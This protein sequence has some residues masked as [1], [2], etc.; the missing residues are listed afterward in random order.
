MTYEQSLV[1]PQRS[2]LLQCIGASKL[3]NPVFHHGQYAPGTVFMLCCDG[4][5]HVILPEEFYQAF[6]PDLMNSTEIMNSR[7]SDLI[8]LNIQ[9]NEDDNISAI[10]IKTH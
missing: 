7:L 1:D 3:V 2:V 8:R 6:R 9:R 5:R 4:F 10:L